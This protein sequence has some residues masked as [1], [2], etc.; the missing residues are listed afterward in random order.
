MLKAIRGVAVLLGAAVIWGIGN[1]V[2]GFS[3]AKHRLSGS[4][5]PAVDIALAN[6]LGGLGLLVL[7]LLGTRGSRKPTTAAGNNDVF[8]RG[9]L[10]SAIAGALKGLN[11]CLFVLSTVYVVATQ[12][13]V[14]ESTYIVWAV[15]MA[16]VFR[17]Q[18]VGLLSVI[19]KTLL[20]C[21]AV[22][23]VT[24]PP[25]FTA[26]SADLLGIGA[27]LS[28]GLS[29]AAFLFIWDDIT[30]DLQT[31][32]AKTRA[33]TMLLG[34]SAATILLGTEALVLLLHRKWWLPFLHIAPQDVLVQFFNGVFVV[35]VVYLLVTVGMSCLRDSPGGASV[36]AAFCL[37]FAIVFTLL[38]ECLVRKFSPAAPQLVG[39]VLFLGAFAWLTRSMLPTNATSSGR[40]QSDER[41]PSEF[42]R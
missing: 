12:S 5:L 6:T 32:H 15:G 41:T 16:V 22:L 19:A 8:F 25:R 1:A 29:Y 27:G 38:T 14:L 23:L 26:S 4:P 20:L 17:H 35:G 21:V 9:P 10:R 42:I 13:L 3:S 2:T 36:I 34:T 30:R 37:S 28:A 24:N 40:S 7:L 11:T 18:R 31:I 33:T 39:I